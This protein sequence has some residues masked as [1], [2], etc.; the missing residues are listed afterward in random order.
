MLT[1]RG[2]YVKST[3]GN[4]Y[5]SGFPDVY[6]THYTHGVRWIEVKLPD[7]KGSKFTDAQWE[8]FPK[9]LANGTRIWILTAATEFE[10]AKL[11]KPCNLAEWLLEKA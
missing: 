7:M 3:H 8:V 11:F 5:Q 1:L 10:Y 6:A 2:W 4:L 9:L